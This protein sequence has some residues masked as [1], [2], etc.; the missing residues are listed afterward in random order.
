MV[1]STSKLSVEEFFELPESDRNYELI[2][3][4]AIPKM[5]PKF[6]HSRIQ[7]TLLLILE[8]WAKNKGRIEPEWAIRLERNGVDWVPIPDV[9]YTSYNRLSADWI[10]DEACPVAPELA[11][12]IISPGQTF[13]DLTQKATDYLQ[14]GVAIVWLIDT[15]AQTITVFYPDTL[16]QTFRGTS[17][18]T[19]KLLPELAITP[20]QIFKQAGL[21]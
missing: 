11:I 21:A 13:G 7:K 15:K 16:P 18:I 17:T 6:F 9:S 8:N 3:G 14:T 5:S 1:S 10:L 2:D 4:R 20:Q 19:H 12:E